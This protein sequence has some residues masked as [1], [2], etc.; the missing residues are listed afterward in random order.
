MRHNGRDPS[1]ANRWCL[2]ALLP[3]L[4][5]ILAAACGGGGATASSPITEAPAT[6]APGQPVTPSSPGSSLAIQFTLN[7]ARTTRAGVYASD[8]SLVRTLWRG[9]RLHAGSVLRSWDQHDDQGLALAHGEY[10]VKVVHHDLRYVWEGVI[11]N[12]SSQAGAPV[13]HRACQVPAS[14]APLGSRMHYAVGYNEGQSGL[15]GFDLAQPQMKRSAAALVDPFVAAVMVATDGQRLYWAN[16]GGLAKKSF[17]AAYDLPSGAPLVFVAGGATCLNRFPDGITCY[18]PQHDHSVLGLSDTLDSLP[19]GL[20]VQR[21]GQLLAVAY[22]GDAAVL[23]ATITGL[24]NPLAIAVD[25]QDGDSVWIAEGGSRQQLRRFDSAGTPRQTLGRNG[26]MAGSAQVAPDR[27]CFALSPTQEQS[28]LAIDDGGA[29]WVVDSGNNR[30]L[31]FSRGGQL[32]ATLAYLPAVYVS[33]VDA[34]NPTRVFANFLE[35]A[36][37]PARPLSDPLAWT[38]VR[39]WL[40]AVPAG[41]RDSETGNRAW[42]G[43]RTV[44]TLANGCTYGLLQVA[45]QPVLVELAADGSLRPST[46][47]RRPASGE[48]AAALYENG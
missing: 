25:P 47:L 8:G 30:L 34:G 32:A 5:Y 4:L 22:A 28:A 13:L 15:H 46:A 42:G 18:P 48:T 16:T 40:P 29:L 11:G 10:T 9:E 3:A 21:Q 44:Q 24:I 38:L 14:L 17:I 26:G 12:T 27:L 45:G 31:K 35:F 33:S 23:A 1:A 36:I 37:D 39:N 19:T 7:E 43:F 41:L 20:S 2:M 6:A